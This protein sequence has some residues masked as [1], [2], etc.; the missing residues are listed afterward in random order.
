MF[1]QTAFGIVF[2]SSRQFSQLIALPY[3]ISPASA[4][5]SIERGDVPLHLENPTLQNNWWQ[6]SVGEYL[7]RVPGVAAFHVTS[8]RITVCPEPAADDTA[9]SLYLFG[10][11]M[12]ALLHLRGVLP[13]HGSAVLLPDG[14]GVAVFTG[15]SAAGKSTLAAALTQRGCSLMADDIA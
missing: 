9:V 2:A 7:L 14:K 4:A 13:L 6:T 10:S 12:G 8:S 15:A 11:V 1:T 3:E 5:V